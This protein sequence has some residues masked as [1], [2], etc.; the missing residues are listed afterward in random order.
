MTTTATEV[1]DAYVRELVAAA[2]PP[3]A[4]QIAALRQLLP[5]VPRQVTTRRAA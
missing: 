1:I 2:P 4:E 5:P 3:T